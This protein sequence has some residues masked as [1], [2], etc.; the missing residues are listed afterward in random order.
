MIKQ[1]GR[2]EM[3]KFLTSLVSIIIMILVELEIMINLEQVVSELSKTTFNPHLLYIELR[4]CTLLTDYSSFSDTCISIR[5]KYASMLHHTIFSA[6]TL[7]IH[8]FLMCYAHC[9]GLQI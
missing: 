2:K 5:S 7:M 4:K 6:K 3:L 1:E 8:H 9:S